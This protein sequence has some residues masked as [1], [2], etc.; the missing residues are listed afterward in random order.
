MIPT[1]FTNKELKDQELITIHKSLFTSLLN[2]HEVPLRDKQIAIKFYEI[3]V[4]IDNIRLFYNR[5]ITIFASALLNDNLES[6]Y[7]HSSHS[8]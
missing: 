2:E 7:K 5:H 3:K 8:K 6:I 4:T 1:Q